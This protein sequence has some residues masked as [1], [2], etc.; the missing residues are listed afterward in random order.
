V[1]VSPDGRKVYIGEEADVTAQGG[2]IMAFAKSWK[3]G[4]IHSWSGGRKLA[5]M[6][7][8]GV[9]RGEELSL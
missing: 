6:P 9:R 4:P 2:S 3:S 5:D 1:H 8:K 7:G